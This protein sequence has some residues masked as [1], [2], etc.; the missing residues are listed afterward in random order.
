MQ[1][2]FHEKIQGEGVLWIGPFAFEAEGGSE[3]TK[4]SIE[5]DGSTITAKGLGDWPYVVALVSNWTAPPQ[6]S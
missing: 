4:S 2:A 6:T 1:P 3:T 5:V